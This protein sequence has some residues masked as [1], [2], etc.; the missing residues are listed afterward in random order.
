MDAT[1]VIGEGA[2]KL[3][4]APPVTA[5][6]KAMIVCL[7]LTISVPSGWWGE[8]FGLKSQLYMKF[9]RSGLEV[10]GTLVKSKLLQRA[11]VVSMNLDQDLYW[12]LALNF[13][14][15]CQSLEVSRLIVNSARNLIN[16]CP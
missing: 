14:I 15:A 4:L 11:F 6:G 10:T 16:P 7:N 1:S 12:S 13:S 8:V 3:F 9:S 2:I 5:E